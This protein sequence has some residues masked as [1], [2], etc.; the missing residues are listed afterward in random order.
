MTKRRCGLLIIAIVSF[1][2]LIWEFPRNFQSKFIQAEHAIQTLETAIPRPKDGAPTP[3]EKIAGEHPLRRTYYYHFDAKVP[4]EVRPAFEKAVMVY[5]QT[6]AVHLIPGTPRGR[7]N[8]IT[9]FT[10]HREADDQRPNY[11]EL[12]EGGP[13][14]ERYV[15]LGTYTINRAHAGMNLAHPQTG[16]RTSVAIHEVGHAIGLDHSESRRSVMYPMDQ[17][18]LKLSAADLKTLHALYI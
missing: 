10:Y 11:L 7:Q 16:I 15:G 2:F 12:G 3:I 4:S 17:G 5:N 9:F 8:G 6:G 1:I 14:I 18:H 13:E